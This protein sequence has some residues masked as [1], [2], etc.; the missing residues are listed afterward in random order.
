MINAEAEDPFGFLEEYI[1]DG[2]NANGDFDNVIEGIDE[3]DD[4]EITP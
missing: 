2:T 3:V 4:G 1:A